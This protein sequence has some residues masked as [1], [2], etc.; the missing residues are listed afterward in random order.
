[1][2]TVPSRLLCVDVGSTWTKAALVDL[3]EARIV[4]TAAVPTTLRPDVMVGV[5][6]AR[7]AVGAADDTPALACS[8]AGGGLRLA[9]VGYERSVTAEAGRRVGLSAGA[10]VVHVAAGELDGQGVRDLRAARPD[11]VLLV[12]G[13]DGGNADVLLHNAARLAAARLTAPVVVAGNR[14]AGSQAA[15]LLAATG[16]RHVVTDNV[17]P[18]IGVIDPEPARTAIRAVFL[19]HVIGGKGLSRDRAFATMVRAATPDAVLA[20]AEVLSAATGTDV[21]L[22]DVGGA[23]TDVYSCLTPEGEDASL[24]KEVVGRLWHART[25]EADLGMRWNADGVVE[26]AAREHLPTSSG[27]VP[28]AASLAERPDHLPVD[29]HEQTLD[30]EIARLAAT[31]GVRRHARP[32]APGEGPRPLA[33]VGLVIGS[34]GVL[35][36]APAGGAAGVLEAVTTDHGG[37][38]RVPVAARTAVDAAYGLFVVGLLARE[39]PDAALALARRLGASMGVGA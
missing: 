39:Q 27:L 19:E 21:L 34:G 4:A 7:A 6:A 9:V 28:Y 31:V 37:G 14:E 23:T 13:T 32:Q 22:V 17:V 12:G 33:D 16:R 2:P 35:R 30:L 36:H 5:Q 18:Q 38:W 26:A 29:A 15:G 1:M 20:G 10:R 11:L 3:G 8:S 25:V 24:R